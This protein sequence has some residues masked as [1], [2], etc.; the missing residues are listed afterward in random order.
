MSDSNYTMKQIEKFSCKKCCEQ[1]NKEFKARI[2][3]II[4]AIEEGSRLLKRLREIE[5]TNPS[6]E[7]RDE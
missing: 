4:K 3:E 5:E 2:P 1:M 7:A 6:N